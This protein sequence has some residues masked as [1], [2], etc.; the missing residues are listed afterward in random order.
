ML[1]MKPSAF[2][3]VGTMRR[4]VTSGVDVCQ[5]FSKRYPQNGNSSVLS[6]GTVMALKEDLPVEPF[7]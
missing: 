3:R 1:T 4:V 7:L 2:N 5:K 6:E